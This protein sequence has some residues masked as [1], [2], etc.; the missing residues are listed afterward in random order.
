MQLTRLFLPPPSSATCQSIHPDRKLRLAIVSVSL[1]LYTFLVSI[2]GSFNSLVRG[3]V[4]AYRQAAY[5]AAGGSSALQRPGL[6]AL[7]PPPVTQHSGRRHPRKGGQIRFTHQQSAQLEKTF[8]CQRYLTPSQRRLLA[9]QLAL[10]ERQVGRL[11]AAQNLHFFSPLSD[12][13]ISFSHRFFC[14]CP[15]CF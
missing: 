7:P 2:Y 14:C 12:P 9:N 13:P 5:L 6:P 10:T 3:I 15:V 4:E 11:S 8:A 1:V